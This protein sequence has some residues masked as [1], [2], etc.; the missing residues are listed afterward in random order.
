[1]TTNNSSRRNLDARGFSLLE[2][3]VT[4]AIT[5]VIM[6]ATMSA[7]GDAWKA[8]DSATLLT[9]LN[10]GLRVAMDVVVRDVL[11]VGQGLPTGR[12][13]TIP[14]G[15]GVTT[16]RIPGPPGTN[17]T[18]PNTATELSAVMPGPGRGPVVNGV[19]TDMITTIAADSAFE[20][21]QLTA[22]TDTTMT[23]ALTRTAP[24]PAIPNGANITDGGPDD[25]DAGDL[26]MLTRGAF[27]ALVQ[28]TVQPTN[29]TITFAGSDSLGLNQ[30]GAADGTVREYR[31]LDPTAAV[32]NEAIDP[33]TATLTSRATRIRMI[34]YYIDATTDP[35]RPR[36]VRRANNGHPTTFNNALGTAVAFDVENLSIS[37]DL[38]DGTTTSTNIRMTDA[39]QTTTTGGCAPV[40][41]DVGRIRKVNVLLGARARR[42]M[43]GSRQLFRN[44]LLTQ[45]SLRS[46]A[47]VDRYQ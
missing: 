11:Q 12:I 15:A 14:S 42:P 9:G 25:I 7:L 26:I 39:D 35:L 16:I 3:L 45:V 5:L 4:M 22:L 2:L 19:A 41:C 20:G 21:R 38:S 46:L 34:T 17:Y 1:M 32:Q 27:S 30:N 28:V 36:L 6:G 31:D 47:F 44:S 24:L 43:K 29:Q 10:T 13:V 8:T 37:Y 33:A 40:A 23:V 18:L